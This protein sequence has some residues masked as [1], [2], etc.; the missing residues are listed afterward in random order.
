MRQMIFST[1]IIALVLLSGCVSTENIE[2]MENTGAD[3]AHGNSEENTPKAVFVECPFGKADDPYPG[4]CGRYR[5]Q[6][7]DGIC[8]LSQ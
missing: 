3:F 5:D 2:D 7:N 4:E 1:L 8:D 6:N